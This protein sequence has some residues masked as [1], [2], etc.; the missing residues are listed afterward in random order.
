MNNPI[1]VQIEKFWKWCRFKFVKDTS[2]TYRDEIHD[3]PQTKKVSVWMY[4]DEDL[5][6]QHTPPIDLNNLFKY[7]V[8]KA[9]E[10]IGA[11]ELSKRMQGWINDVIQCG[12]NPEVSL[13][14]LL[15]NIR[16]GGDT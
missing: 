10:E 6:R 8:P 3:E 4:P 1:E 13:F 11:D 5:P 2:I 15:N 14:H 7:P 12:I 9:R 16:Q